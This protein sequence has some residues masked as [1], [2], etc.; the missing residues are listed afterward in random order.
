MSKAQT[1][2]K[3]AILSATGGTLVKLIVGLFTGSMAMI[4]S[5]IDSLGDLVVSILNLFIVKTSE[6]TADG[7]HNYGHS[8]VEWMW[9]M[10]EGAFIFSAGLFVIYESIHKLILWS[11][12][13]N[14]NAGL[15]VMFFVSIFTFITVRYLKKVAD[16]TGS[17]VIKSDALH[18]T[19]DLYMN[20]GVF[21]SLLIVKITG[22]SFIDSIISSGIAVYMLYSSYWIIKTGF[23]ILM[24]KSIP[25]EEVKII[26]NILN[27]Y[28]KE[29]TIKNYH[30]LKT[31]Q[32]KINYVEYHI[33]LDRSTTVKVEH[34]LFM[35]MRA[36][37][38]DKLWTDTKVSVHTDYYEHLT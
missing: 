16:E 14:E 4:S 12:I 33:Q 13:T 32:W 24:D 10:F 30:D 8:K 2:V 26:E 25:E 38:I 37:I 1:A 3:W 23:D 18:Y 28:V 11:E 6:K 34:D 31:R 36:R 7:D 15:L 27:D 17:L 5:A 9:A 29:W 19:T 21:I 22:L 20:I 35:E